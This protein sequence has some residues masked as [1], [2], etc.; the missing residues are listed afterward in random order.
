MT[1]LNLRTA[2]T[3]ATAATRLLLLLSLPNLGRAHDHGHGENI[4]DG[5]VVSP[6]PL[7]GVL[8]MHI[9]GMILS[10]GIIFPFGMVLGMVRNR[11]HVPV[12]LVGSTIAVL[13]WFLGHA[14]GGRQFAPNIHADF[15]SV[16]MLLLAA[17]VGVGV[18]LKLHIERGFMGRIRPKIVTLHGVLGKAMPV[19]AWVQMCFGGITA[20]GFCRADHTGNCLA[21]FIMGSSFIG[22]GIIMTIMMV[23]GQGWL[24]RTGKSQEFWD[25]AVIAAW[26][27]VN[28]FTEHRWGQ[29]WAGNDIQ[30]TAMGIVWW[31][32]GLLGLFLSRNSGGQPK[33]NLVPGMVLILTGY[34]MSAHPQHNPLSAMVHVVFGYTLMAAGLARIIEISFILGDKP[35]LDEVASWQYLPPYLLFA[36]GFIFQC[37]NEEQVA[38][39]SSIGIDHVSYLLVLFSVAFLMFLYTNVLIH[40]Y[41]VNPL[42]ST[43]RPVGGGGEGTRSNGH[44]RSTE[45]PHE[46]EQFELEGLMSDSDDEPTS[47]RKRFLEGG[48]RV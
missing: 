27:M 6:D 40:T 45:A 9:A 48:E 43:K 44:V 8:W 38:W 30:H 33:R 14:H 3:A 47:P 18:F 34:A 23:L 1:W 39:V 28:T 19:V 13:S 11:W 35:S 21:H 7:D 46:A 31:A 41:L 10:F 15:A 2:E 17:Q 42:P 24:R 37:A 32:A 20:L 16:L 26:G 29:K 4:P 12:Q 5:A 22:Y 36:S 25:S